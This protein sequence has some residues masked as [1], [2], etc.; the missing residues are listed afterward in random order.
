[1]LDDYGDEALRQ[2]EYMQEAS[3]ENEYDRQKRRNTI[4]IE[5]AE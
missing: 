3:L 4:D 2:A 1:M 5:N